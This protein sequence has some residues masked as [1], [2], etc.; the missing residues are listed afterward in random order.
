[1]PK[2]VMTSVKV[3]SAAEISPYLAPGSVMVKNLRLALDFLVENLKMHSEEYHH[4]TDAA[5]VKRCEAVLEEAISELIA[6]K[7][8]EAG[9]GSSSRWRKI[10]H[11]RWPRSLPDDGCQ[12]Q[13]SDIRNQISE[14]RPRVRQ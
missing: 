3:T 8:R 1:M 12:G 7:E 13:G 4:K 5:Q 10:S 11:H 9:A 14:I 2:S 6:R